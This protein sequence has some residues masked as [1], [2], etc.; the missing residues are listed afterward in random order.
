MKMRHI[1]TAAL[2][3]YFGVAGAYAQS[4]VQA[5]SVTMTFSGNGAEGSPINLQYPNTTTIEENVAGNGALGAFLFR[6]VTAESNTPSSQPPS[7]CSGQT[8]LYFPR[9]AGAGIF[10]FQDG[11]LLNVKLTQGAD[12]IDLVANEGHCTLTLQVTG[13]TGRFKGASGVLTYA[14]TALPV[15]ADYFGNPVFF[16]EAGE[17]TGTISAVAM[18]DGQ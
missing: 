5:S 1:A 13:G 7:T 9:V 12:C 3:L 17:I 4:H 16:D 14:E 8:H 6:N 18:G 10:V 15:L 11:S 2:M